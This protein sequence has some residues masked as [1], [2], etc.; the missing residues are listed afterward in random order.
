MGKCEN[1]ISNSMKIYSEA[2]NWGI[3]SFIRH[4]G[5][6]KFDAHHDTRISQNRLYKWNNLAIFDS[7]V[8]FGFLYKNVSEKM[9]ML[10]KHLFT[11]FDW[12]KNCE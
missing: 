8:G 12:R 11:L 2:Y 10:K 6:Y 1:S 4:V 3:E 9:V 5:F 7:V